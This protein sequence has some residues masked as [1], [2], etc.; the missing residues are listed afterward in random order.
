MHMQ[1]LLLLSAALT[2]EVAVLKKDLEGS[3][4]ELGLTKRQL[5][6]NKGK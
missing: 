3:Q 4:D 5:E 6:D 2:T 1:A